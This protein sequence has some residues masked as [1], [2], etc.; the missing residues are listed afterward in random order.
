MDNIQDKVI[1]IMSESLALNKDDIHQDSRLFVDLGMDS[2]DFLDI[3]FTLESTFQV[4]IRDEDFEKL[5]RLDIP[6]DG[7]SEEGYLPITEVEN[8]SKWIPLLKSQPN[9][10]QLT[11][12]QIFSFLTIESIVKLILLKQAS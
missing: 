2:L 7:Q 11:R 6:V 3:V 10:D 5:A 9:R 8:L 1:D 4:K 12:E